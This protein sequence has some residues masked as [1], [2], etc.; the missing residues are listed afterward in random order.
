MELKTFSEFKEERINESLLG[1]IVSTVKN[2][3]TYYFD[4]AKKF[5]IN[6]IS[7]VDAN[8]YN[9]G[10][11]RVVTDGSNMPLKNEI[12]NNFKVETTEQIVKRNIKTLISS[13]DSIWENED[14]Y[15]TINESLNTDLDE[16]VD[17]STIHG[18]GEKDTRT[19]NWQ[20]KEKADGSQIKNRLPEINTDGVRD[21]LKRMLSISDTRSSRGSKRTYAHPMLFF[22]AP[23]VG[24]TALVNS[25]IEAY[26]EANK[27]S[28]GIIVID[29]ANLGLDS[30]SL[31]MP[32]DNHR[33]MGVL[34]KAAGLD[35][36]QDEID[37][38]G[39]DTVTDRVKEWL[40][41]WK[42]TGDPEM[43]KKANAIANGHKSSSGTTIDGGIIFFDELLRVQDPGVFGQLMNLI[44]ARQLGEYVLGSKWNIV[45][46]SNRPNDDRAVANA[47]K[48]APSAMFNRFAGIYHVE[49]SPDDWVKWASSKGPDGRSRVDLRLVGLIRHNPRILTNIENN[50]VGVGEL[51]GATPRSWTILSETLWDW[52]D[53][54]GVS[55]W[56]L[57]PQQEL[58]R[59]IFAII[60]TEFGQLVVDDIPT[61]AEEAKKK[62][63]DA[64]PKSSSQDDFLDIIDAIEGATKK[65]EVEPLVAKLKEALD[66][67]SE[68]DVNA[69]LSPKIATWEAPVSAQ[70]NF[71]IRTVLA[72]FPDLTGRFAHLL[73]KS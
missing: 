26:N 64:A 6:A 53:S 51:V 69:F 2:K 7:P 24:K 68:K 13:C 56:V 27:G 21:R 44:L 33:T 47:L 15:E 10:G 1:D 19:G 72:K 45:C 61:W 37:N 73:P 58:N 57:L 54:E 42:P 29:C 23:G 28:K 50:E 25:A 4:K 40:P 60:G 49:P 59:D 46:V 32:D 39:Q 8:G 30:L 34:A 20:W 18:F 17:E 14:L 67:M 55:D 43:D 12:P 71:I 52:A 36:S 31:V 38:L 11:V 48:N 65:K 9:K 35:L 63:K 62:K 66:T 16:R 41:M 22:G 70:V 3:V 5:L